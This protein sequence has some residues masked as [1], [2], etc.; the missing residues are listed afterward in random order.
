MG[1]TT[2]HLPDSVLPHSSALIIGNSGSMDDV[3]MR[4]EQVASTDA[5]VLLLGETGTGKGLAARA[6]HERSRRARM[7]LAHIDCASLPATLIE[8]ELFGHERGAFTDAVATQVGRFE[9]ANGGTV[10]LDE[11]GELPLELQSK[12]LRVL[13]TGQFERVGSPKT[14][15][16]D[17]RIVAA[18]NRVLS[19]EVKRNA[20]RGD[21]FYR[22]N[23]FPITLPPLRTRRGDI[24]PLAEHLLRA[25]AQRH[26]REFDPISPAVMAE[27]EAYDWPG[28]VR[29]LENVIERAVIVSQGRELRLAESLAASA[30]VEPVAG[31]SLIEVERAHITAVLERCGWRIEGVRG[32]ARALGLKP[33]TLRSL[34]QRLGIGRAP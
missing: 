19:D 5:T 8:K 21:L 31:T 18:T 14:T 9:L 33:S 30:F 28:N 34:M 15:T 6:I 10:F 2:E 12:L 7:R 22:L 23:V 26:H 3:R 29:E 4:I 16:V 1:I 20:F 11:V 24:A 27:L 25:I 32:G 17:V 13:Q